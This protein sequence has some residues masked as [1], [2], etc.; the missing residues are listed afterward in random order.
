[1]ELKV[2]DKVRNQK[3]IITT[4]GETTLARLFEGKAIVKSAEAKCSPE[5]TFDF[6]FGARLAFE[7]LMGR[8]GKVEPEPK[9][10]PDKPKFKVGD[11]VK[12]VAN[13]AGHGF[14][15]GEVVKLVAGD[16]SPFDFVAYYLDDRDYW[17]VNR[18]DIEPYTEPKP[19][20]ET[21]ALL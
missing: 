2:G 7:R 15:I 14:K 17:F 9:L 10:E 8:K 16:A 3:I 13:S 20:G 19:G 1:M 4:D 11:E 5:D 6:G 21:N 18:S 12:I